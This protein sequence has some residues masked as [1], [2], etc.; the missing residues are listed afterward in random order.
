[1]SKE[2]PRPSRSSAWL[3]VAGA[4]GLL[5]LAAMN[6]TAGGGTSPRREMTE[7]ARLMARAE[8]AVRECR[9]AKGLRPDAA[10]DPNATGLIGVETSPITTSLGDPAAKRTTTNPDFAALVVSL[11]D[12]A[13]VRRGDAVAVG[14]S[15]SFPA[16][17]IATLAAARAMG[18]DA[19]VISSLGASEWGANDP[20]FTWLDMAEC[21]RRA[22]GPI[23]VRPVAL[24]LGGEE[25]VGRN[26]EPAGRALLVERIRAS[27]LPFIDEAGLAANVAERLRF[28]AAAAGG[29]PLR[30]FVN[31]GGSSANIG[32]NAEV[33]KLR[34]GLARE[35][36]VPPPA[37]R[38]VLQEMAARKVPVV[39]L[40]NVRGLC[41]RYGLPWDP[42][43]LPAPGTAGLTRRAAARRGVPTWLSAAYVLFVVAF[44]VSRRR[45]L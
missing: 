38:G 20:A 28:Y 32:T 11:L 15:S 26:M 33:L 37:E 42:R 45:S 43:P 16:L 21:L 31:I 2:R 17:V 41:R 29:R 27:G 24:A 18:A 14:A 36:F 9:S 39:H 44:L 23:D 10:A 34:P 35:V 40:L 13:G 19:L 4:A 22:A 7:A 25:D 1:M 6:F 12:E 30:A 8:A 5:F 3:S